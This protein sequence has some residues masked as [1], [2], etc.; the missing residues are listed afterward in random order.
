MHDKIT[1]ILLSKQV[2]INTTIH[3]SLKRLQKSVGTLHVRLR[4]IKYDAL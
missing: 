4:C 3:R 1:S 2:R